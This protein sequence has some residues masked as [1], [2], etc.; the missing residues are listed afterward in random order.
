VMQELGPAL[1][2]KQRAALVP[3]KDAEKK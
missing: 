1:A 3:S 2:K